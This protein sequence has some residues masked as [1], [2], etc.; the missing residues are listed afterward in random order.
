[1]NYKTQDLEILQKTDIF[2][3]LT[4][5][6]I[7]DLLDY[8]QLQEL[9]RKQ[10]ILSEG[11]P[12]NGLYII[13]DG[14]VEIF[15]PKNNQRIT[16]VHIDKL[17]I[18]DCFGEYSLIDHGKVSASIRAHTSL[19]ICHM[20]MQN[21]QTLVDENYRSGRY[22]YENLLKLFIHRLRS[23]IQELDLAFVIR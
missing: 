7:E 12:G 21:F 9:K 1:M 4:I 14:S 13:L 23:N 5:D 3:G 16:E 15:L 18:G 17:K 2:R 22:I 19:R 20:S 6:D 11:Q 10:E 8:C